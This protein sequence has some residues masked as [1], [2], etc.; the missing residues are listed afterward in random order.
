MWQYAHL[1]VPAGTTIRV[2]DSSID[3]DDTSWWR[4]AKE[5]TY[6]TDLGR[7]MLKLDGSIQVYWRITSTFRLLDDMPAYA[8]NTFFPMCITDSKLQG[9]MV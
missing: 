8:C 4:R 1:Q 9:C 2:Y 3:P 5:A 6:E 7:R